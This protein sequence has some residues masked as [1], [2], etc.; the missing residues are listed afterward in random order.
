LRTLLRTMPVLAVLAL[1]LSSCADVNLSSETEIVVDHDTV[2]ES[3]D[4]LNGDL[5]VMTGNVDVLD[6]GLVD[7]SIVVVEGDVFVDGEV[8]GDVAVGTGDLEIGPSAV[9]DGD[10]SVMNGSL[11]EDPAAQVAGRTSE[12][13]IIVPEIDVGVPEVSPLGALIYLLL[14]SLIPALIAA[15]IAAIWP[16]N[17]LRMV[18]TVTEEPIAAG[19]VGIV[20]G[21]LAFPLIAVMFATMCLAWV[22]LLALAVLLVAVLF[23]WTALGTEIGQRLGIHL[24]SEWPVPAAAA[25]GTWILSVVLALIE[26]IPCFGA[27]ISVLVACVALGAALLSHF[28]RRDYPRLEGIER[29]ADALNYEG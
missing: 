17:V 24:G 8:T 16:Q 10:A 11:T 27:L 12:G 19:T 26:L 18:R 23:G 25:I 14:R 2:V 6:G 15:L 9:I 5:L 13:S 28:G 22:G 21:A 3:G 4:K 7:G 29:A 1:L 20:A